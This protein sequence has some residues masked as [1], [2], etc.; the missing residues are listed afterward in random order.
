KNNM[1]NIFYTHNRPLLW[2]FLKD[3][4]TETDSGRDIIKNQSQE[5]LNKYVRNVHDLPGGI[6][7]TLSI[8][9]LYFI[10]DSWQ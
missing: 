3:T 2:S 1:R 4:L 5:N 8:H 10:T 6:R 7:V 9:I